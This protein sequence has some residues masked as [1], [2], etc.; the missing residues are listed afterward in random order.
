MTQAII[1]DVSTH[2][3]ERLDPVLPSSYDELV[4]PFRSWGF[5]G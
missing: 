2:Y 5:G 1:L 3:F 4:A